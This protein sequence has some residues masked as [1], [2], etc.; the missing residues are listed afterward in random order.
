MLKNETPK[1][2]LPAIAKAICIDRKKPKV[3]L[4]ITARLKPPK[5]KYKPA[6]KKLFV[7]IC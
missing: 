7:L 3:S 5:P 6:M 4:A 2:I 1:N